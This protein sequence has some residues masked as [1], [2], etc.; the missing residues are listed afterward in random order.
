MGK[1]SFLRGAFILGL[2]GIMVNVLGAFFRIPLGNIIGSEGMGYYQTSFPIYILLVTISASGFPTAIS[3]VVSE[4]LALEDSKGAY[5]VFKVSFIALI[6]TGI[7]SF[8]ILFFG[9]SFIVNNIIKSPKA[10]YSMLAI[11]PAL[12][13]IPIMSAF[14]GYFQGRQEMSPTAVSQIM[15]QLGRVGL[16]LYLAFILLSRGTEYAAAGASFGGTAGAIFGTL[17]IGFIYLKNK[18]SIKDEIENSKNFK[19]E[20]TSE[21]IKKLLSIAIPITIGT[22]ILPI[23][24]VVDASMVV[25]R[26]QSIGFSYEQSNSLFGQLTGMAGTLINFPQVLTMSIAMSLVPVISHFHTIKDIDS[27]KHNTKLGIRTSILIGLPASF[28]LASLSTP[29]IKLLYPKEPS[30]VGEILL[31]LS[32]S[33]ILLG[34]IQSTTAILQGIEKANIPVINIAIGL[35]FKIAINYTLVGVS[36]FNVKGAALGNIGAYIVI[37]ILNFYHIKKIL[38]IKF[39]FTHYI[40]KPLLSSLIMSIIVVTSYKLSLSLFGNSM[41]CLVSIGIGTL[42]YGASIL[43]TGGISE[44][45]ILIMPKGQKIAAFLKKYKILR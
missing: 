24:N 23:M 16:G 44:G 42:V 3:K 38:N 36:Y 20:S 33:V 29:I 19:E 7:V 45:E 28:G 10:Y 41:S 17:Y 27:L 26:L 2:A 43:L 6:I 32:M 5:K 35:V 11:S 4:K 37:V 12:L 25:R 15:E 1:D 22:S 34:L 39:E 21:I 18:N 8:I 30:S 13:F 14:R 40:A 9:A 31:Y